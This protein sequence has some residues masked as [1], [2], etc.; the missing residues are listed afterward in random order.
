MSSAT[1]ELSS[2]IKLG[3]DFVGGTHSVFSTIKNGLLVFFS[4]LDARDLRLVCKEF[5]EAVSEYAWDDKET[6]ILNVGMWRRVHPKARTAKLHERVV[7]NDFVQLRGVL[8]V[9]MTG[10]SLITNA[11]FVNLVG[12]KKLIMNFCHQ[13]E[14]TDHA[15]VNLR[16]IK[17][18][19]MI[20][21]FQ[22][23]DAAFEHLR[24]IKDLNITLCTQLSNVAFENLKG[25]QILDFSFCSQVSITDVAFQN[26]KGIKKLYMEGCDQPTITNAAFQ[27]LCGIDTLNMNSCKQQ[28]ITDE[29]FES[30]NGIRVLDMSHCNQ[31]TITDDA[32][33]YLGSN[34]EIL[35]INGCNQE[36]IT[37][38]ARKYLRNIKK[39]YAIDV[40]MFHCWN[41]YHGNGLF[42]WS[43]CDCDCGDWDGY[44]GWGEIINRVNWNGMLHDHRSRWDLYDEEE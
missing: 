16:G 26:L 42:E 22:I 6:V 44:P 14:I 29:A 7:D 13:D 34:L 18:L 17:I 3:L 20:N 38:N 1:H 30:L 15:F 31:Q 41:T 40:D 24:G 32:F 33:K 28:E 19:H 25:I 37:W 4:T 5:K 2:S 9:D 36:Q 11:A 35:K 23:T 8:H 39:I 10:C 27:Y 43:G 12:I 21:C